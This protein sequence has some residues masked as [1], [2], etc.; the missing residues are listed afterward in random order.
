MDVGIGVGLASEPSTGEMKLASLSGRK[1]AWL[2]LDPDRSAVAQQR[3]ESCPSVAS[4]IVMWGPVSPSRAPPGCRPAVWRTSGSRA[5][6]RQ[7]EVGKGSKWSQLPPPVPNAAWGPNSRPLPALRRFESQLRNVDGQRE[8][9]AD[10]GRGAGAAPNTVVPVREIFLH[11][12]GEGAVGRAASTPRYSI[13]PS[14]SAVACATRLS[15]LVGR[16]DES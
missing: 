6:L 2:Q 14:K 4:P 7:C 11:R 9:R 15:V 13:W 16:I 3:A 5:L 10:R 1:N 8:L 12:H